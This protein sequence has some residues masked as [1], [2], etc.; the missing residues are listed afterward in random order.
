MK[1]P[2][3]TRRD[4]EKFCLTELWEPRK[5]ATGK[6]G[7]HHCNYELALHDG[8]ILY[9][10]ISHP[11]DRSAYGQD[12]W[13]HILRDQLEVENPEFWE[14]VRNGVLPDRGALA[15]VP[16]AAI[17]AGVVSILLGTFHLPEAEVKQMTAAEAIARM[18]ELYSRQV[19]GQAK[20]PDKQV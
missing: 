3:A 6:T 1:F 2:P 16:E 19:T 12:L 8:R 20:G 11:V 9:T 5:T 18:G 14:C 17:P 15:E 4:H 7:T 13:G 10:R